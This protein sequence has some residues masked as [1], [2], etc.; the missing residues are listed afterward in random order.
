MDVLNNK[1]FKVEL[2]IVRIIGIL[3]LGFLALSGLFMYTEAH[4]WNE[5]FIIVKDPIYTLG[6]LIVF[7]L[8]FFY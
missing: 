3:F 4:D 8:L 2:L 7:V 5:L 6:S 1:L